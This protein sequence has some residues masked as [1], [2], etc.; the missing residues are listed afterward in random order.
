MCIK[1]VIHDFPFQKIDEILSLY[2]FSFLFISVVSKK[3]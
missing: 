3:L 2:K 1:I